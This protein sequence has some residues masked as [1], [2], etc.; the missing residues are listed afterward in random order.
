[1]ISHEI[2]SADI[3]STSEDKGHNDELICPL[4]VGVGYI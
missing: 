4:E 1:M 2:M 3:R